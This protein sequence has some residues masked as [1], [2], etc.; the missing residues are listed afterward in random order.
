M[1]K[2]SGSIEWDPPALDPFLRRLAELM[3]TIQA[4]PVPAG[5]LLPAYQPYELGIHRPP[6]WASR[7]DVWLRA[8]DVLEG[9]APV[10]ERLFIH[11]DYHPGNVLWHDEK[12]SGVVDW[13]NAS[14]GSPWADVRHCRVTSLGS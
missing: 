6:V 3:P 7:P 12:V 5:V 11:R 10:R 9:Q 1:T 4:T 14:I 8:I 13:V 2:L